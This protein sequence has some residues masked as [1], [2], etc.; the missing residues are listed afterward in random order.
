MLQRRLHVGYAR[1]GRM[2]DD[3]EQ[4]GVIGPHQGSKPREVIMTYGEWLERNH[5]QG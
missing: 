4:L 2:I 3:M 5:N 1:A